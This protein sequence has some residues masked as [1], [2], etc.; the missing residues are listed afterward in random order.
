MF[1]HFIRRKKNKKQK[2]EL[3]AKL[4]MLL[5]DEDW[6]FSDSPWGKKMTRIYIGE[7]RFELIPF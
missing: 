5:F 1:W 3:E 7:L 6:D 4:N 2:K